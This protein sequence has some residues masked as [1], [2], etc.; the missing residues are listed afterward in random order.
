M[1]RAA[2]VRVGDG[3]RNLGGVV[4]AVGSEVGISTAPPTRVR[5]EADIDVIGSRTHWSWG[6]NEEG[7]DHN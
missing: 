1:E 2:S 3:E 4:G 7:A 6:T 5:I